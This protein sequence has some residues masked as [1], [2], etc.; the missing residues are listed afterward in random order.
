MTIKLL[1]QSDLTNITTFDK[2]VLKILKPYFDIDLK[3]EQFDLFFKNLL[4]LA[5]HNLGIAHCVQH[6][7]SPRLSMLIAFENKTAPRFFQTEYEKLIG[8]NSNLKK[9]DS[10]KLVNNVVSGT[11]HWITNLHQSDYGI[12]SVPIESDM[13][14]LILFDFTNNSNTH[15]ID[16]TQSIQIGME[17]AHAGSLIVKDY[18]I[19]DGYLLGKRKYFSPGPYSVVSSWN[20]YCFITNYLGCITGL[21]NEFKEYTVKNNINI[22]YELKKM[23]LQISNIRMLWEDNLISIKQSLHINNIT[24][25]FWHRRNTQYTQTKNTLLLLI[26]LI[27]EIVDSSWFNATGSQNQKFRDALVFSTHMKSLFKNLEEKILHNFI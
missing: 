20:D 17:V 11:K 18:I 1:K 6:N 2:N 12:F 13:E 9:N 14:A 24:D 7:H 26:N 22:D 5:T 19:P 8:C 4:T 10:L 16:S 21:Y 27:L 23:E 25:K 3:S 15:T